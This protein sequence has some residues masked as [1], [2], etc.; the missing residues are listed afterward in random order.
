MSTR[1]L[2]LRRLR[3]ILDGALIILIILV[4]ATSFLPFH[5]KP[6]AQASSQERLAVAPLSLSDMGAENFQLA[7]GA[8][9][10]DN[11]TL[12]AMIAAENATL[13]PPQYFVEL[14]L[15]SR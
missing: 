9:L 1:P 5:A 7:T 15:I 11:N 10:L 8:G 13:T 14:P 12:A 2:H 6:A 4:A 3:T